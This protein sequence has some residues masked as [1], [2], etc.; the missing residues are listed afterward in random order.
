MIVIVIGMVMVMVI[1]I[2]IVIVIESDGQ[3]GV[4]KWYLVNVL[5]FIKLQKGNCFI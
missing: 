5:R 3:D 2:V 4:G 1:V